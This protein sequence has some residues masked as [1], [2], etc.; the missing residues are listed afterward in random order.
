MIIKFPLLIKFIGR[1]DTDA[2]TIWPFIFIKDTIDDKLLRHEKIH[3]EQQKR[4]Y[5]LGFYIKYFYYQIRY[6]YENNPY[7]IEAKEG[8]K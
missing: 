6:G 4:G 1:K 3:L 5:L 7:E 8:S 2:M